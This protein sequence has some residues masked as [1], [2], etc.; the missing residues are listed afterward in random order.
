M[1]R[2]VTWV[3]DTETQMDAFI[4]GVEWVNDGALELSGSGP[5]AAAAVE[6]ED[7][8]PGW[9]AIFDDEDGDGD[10]TFTYPGPG[11]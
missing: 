7:L 1:S 3:F 2:Q 8:V 5:V 4:A 6:G 9:I 10:A 11:N